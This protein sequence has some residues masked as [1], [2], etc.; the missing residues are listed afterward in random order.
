M[1]PKG[2]I[3]LFR[4]VAARGHVVRQYALAHDKFSEMEQLLHL[5]GREAEAEG[6][7]EYALLCLQAYL[8]ETDDP[9]IPPIDPY[10][11]GRN[12]R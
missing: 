10:D 4:D 3:E 7:H 2:P 12:D 9:D 6:A 11:G 5:E 1:N 8:N